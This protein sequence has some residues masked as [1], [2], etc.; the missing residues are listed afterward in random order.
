MLLILF[1]SVSQLERKK[2]LKGQQEGERDLELIGGCAMY[3]AGERTQGL[4][5]LGKCSTPRLYLRSFL[6]PIWLWERDDLDVF[7]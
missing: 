1:F 7:Q 3:G 5:M 2:C 6:E 4:A